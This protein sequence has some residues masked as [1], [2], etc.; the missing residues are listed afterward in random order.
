[1]IKEDQ[2]LDE[3]AKMY[4]NL[5]NVL[6]NTLEKNIYSLSVGQEAAVAL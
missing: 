6:A 2:T 5:G 4:S 3:T 1:M